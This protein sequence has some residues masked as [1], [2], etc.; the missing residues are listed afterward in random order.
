[1][2]SKFKIGRYGID[3]KQPTDTHDIW[4]TKITI[5]DIKITKT[6]PRYITLHIKTH[7]GLLYS[8]DDV[9]LRRKIYTD[10]YDNEYLKPIYFVWNT[11]I[12]PTTKQIDSDSGFDILHLQADDLFIKI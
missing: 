3:I 12:N 6:T 5:D 8:L 4:I 11:I 2:G 1:M 7:H 10:E 9:K